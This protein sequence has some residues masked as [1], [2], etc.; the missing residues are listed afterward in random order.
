VRLE[1]E[2]LVGRQ[3]GLDSVDHGCGKVSNRLGGCRHGLGAAAA[4]AVAVSVSV[5][6]VETVAGGMRMLM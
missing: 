3:Q 5:S 6:V 2:G 1:R 4:V